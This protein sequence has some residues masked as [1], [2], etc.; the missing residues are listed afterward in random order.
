[1]GD[2]L[3]HKSLFQLVNNV[4]TVRVDSFKGGFEWASIW[5]E[6]LPNVFY[7]ELTKVVLKDLKSVLDNEFVA[8]G[9][10]K[11]LMEKGNLVKSRFYH[12]VVLEANHSKMEI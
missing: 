1:M 4:R 3:F 6:V 8:Y 12:I 10:V 9:V 7:Q 5:F 11:V 2:S